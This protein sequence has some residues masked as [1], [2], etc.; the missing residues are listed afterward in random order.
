MAVVILIGNTH[1]Y[2]KRSIEKQWPQIYQKG[3]A[4]E[5]SLEVTAEEVRSLAL[6]SEERSHGVTAIVE[7]SLSLTAAEDGASC[8]V[9]IVSC[10]CISEVQ[11][12]LATS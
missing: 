7:R 2:S 5:V 9:M 1:V 6:T 8:K 10:D 11:Q 4:L 12:R 3:I